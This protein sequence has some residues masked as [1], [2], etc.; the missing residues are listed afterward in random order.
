[1]QQP[2]AERV[3]AGTSPGMLVS[4]FWR[5]FHPSLLTAFL[6]FCLQRTSPSNSEPR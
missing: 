1:M 6:E 4:S 3:P 5:V 2:P